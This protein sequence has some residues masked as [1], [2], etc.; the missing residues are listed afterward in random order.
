MKRLRLVA[1]LWVAFLCGCGSSSGVAGLGGSSSGSSSSSSSS[2][3][4]SSSSGGAAS[5]I[6]TVAAAGSGSG[7]VTSVPE[8]IDCGS[9][10]T[11]GYTA[12]VAVTLTAT[13]ASGSSFSGWSG[14]CSGT[15]ACQLTLDAP[16][17]VTATF[18]VS[19]AAQ[20]TLQVKK[21]GV[22]NGTV[23]SDPAGIQCGALCSAQFAQGTVV[24]L[25]PTPDIGAVFTGWSGACTGTASCQLALTA[26]TVVTATFD[27]GPGAPQG[28]TL[29][30]DTHVHDDHSYDGSLPRQI[31]NDTL[32]GNVSVADQIGWGELK[33]LDFMPLTDHRTYTQ[34][35]DP[36]WQSSKLILVP[37]EEANGSP[38][39]TVHGG[40]DSI[41]QQANPPGGPG[42]VSLQQS[43][44]NAHSEDANWGTAHP[45]DGETNDDGTPNDNANAVGVDT[46]E[47]WNKASGPDAEIDYA[48]NR[49]NAGYR[50]GVAGACDDHFKELWLIAGPS[51]PTTQVFAP[52]KSE[53]G[54]VSGLRSGHTA[55]YSGFPGTPMVT[56]EAD[57]QKDG[58]FEAIQG[59]EV[60]AAPGTHGQ[61]RITVNNGFGTTVYLYQSPGR[62]AGPLKTFHPGLIPFSSTYL[63]DVDAGTD[64]SWYRVEV[65]GVGLPSGID[66]SNL[67]LQSLVLFNQLRAV[68][69][70]IFVSPTLATAQPA[71][72]IPADQGVDDGARTVLGSQ[73]NF[74]G[75]PDVAQSKA[76]THVVAELHQA[77][78]SHIQYLRTGAAGTAA[79]VDL[80]PAS[81][82]AR[83]PRV[84]AAGSDVWVVW[85][86]DRAGE[87]PYRTAIYM[88][89]S[90][91]EG[92]TWEPEVAIRSPDQGRAEHPVIATTAGKVLVAW[93]EIASG[94]PF[95][96][97]AQMLG[98]AGAP[99][100]LSAAGKSFN[101]ASPLDTRTARYPASVWPT[102]AAANG[103]FAV[104]WQDDRE[105][106]DP[107][108]TGGTGYGE[109][110]EPDDWQIY[111]TQLPAGQSVWTTPA[112]L[113]AHD[114][115]DRHPTLAYAGD[116]SLVAA[117]DTKILQP[118]GVFT[119]ILSASQATAGASW[120][121]PQAV[122]LDANS[123]AEFPRLG[124]DGAGNVVL[125]RQDTRSADWRWRLVATHR[126]ADGSWAA[127]TVIPGKGNN[128]WPVLSGGTL[129]FVSSRD[130]QRLQRD[131]TQEI[132]SMTVP[133]AP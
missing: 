57:F 82:D 11:Q 47:V 2:S 5:Y 23:T 113:G 89:H 18:A 35:Y 15:G 21:A 101:A 55:V 67:T 58:V 120:S 111:A 125:V 9:R 102:V 131:R 73:G 103:S 10:C 8:G 68:A 42:W 76:Y 25:T 118:A 90:P 22:S 77:G 51:S 83:F 31:S 91:D 43:I 124:L 98:G 69:S 48:E 26:D 112:Y 100:N 19:T 133:A 53:L 32:P 62:S 63:V 27:G 29:G 61:L 65:R 1:V 74:T 49:W 85:Q 121:A 128:L 94:K 122:A 46:V 78:A 36:L 75:F 106:K 116:G 72:P 130:A 12:G 20:K 50:F 14:D 54:I 44:W 38:H 79:P 97:W 95:D 40:I 66:T 59:D 129:V 87:L 92:A 64:P 114:H 39:A 30:G 71:V 13:P 52:R 127:P 96:V 80:V 45:D 86:D 105:D 56:L 4:G 119:S 7:D 81:S 41:V 110:T 108:W 60:V 24:T 28:L 99:V 37:G 16:H 93:Q 123:G 70:P 34:Q 33:G 132:Y 109:G 84:A 17:Q 115:A 126:L 107:L 6:L 104:A 88:R 117:W 3:S